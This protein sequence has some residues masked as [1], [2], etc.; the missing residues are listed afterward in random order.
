MRDQ[1]ERMQPFEVMSDFSQVPSG[2]FLLSLDAD[3][4]SCT[5]TE[6]ESEADTIPGQISS[7]TD[8]EMS[9]EDEL[10][11]VIDLRSE[12]SS[13]VELVQELLTPEQELQRMKGEER[14]GYFHRV[15]LAQLA[16]AARVRRV[17]EAIALPA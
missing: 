10:I 16:S 17:C 6:V 2:N 7:C 9:E 8:V 15:E 11:E 4:L 14:Y 5:P 12:S 13:E 3:E 1:S